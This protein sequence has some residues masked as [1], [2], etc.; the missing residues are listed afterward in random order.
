L[1]S[2]TRKRIIVTEEQLILV[3]NQL[4]GKQLRTEQGEKFKIV[5]LGRRER[6]DGPDFQGAL[7]INSSGQ[8]LRG[9]IEVHI[10]T[11]DWYRH[12]HQHN[13]KYNNV[14]LHIVAQQHPNSITRTKNGK[15]IPILYQ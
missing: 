7:I 4:L 11:S 3:I 5:Y 6:N 1:L 9:D 8:V 10:Y 14:I 13:T 2:N 12:G 15:S